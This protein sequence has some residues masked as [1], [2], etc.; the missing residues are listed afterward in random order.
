MVGALC[1]NFDPCGQ[2][3]GRVTHRRRAAGGDLR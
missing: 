2:R 1:V 3:K